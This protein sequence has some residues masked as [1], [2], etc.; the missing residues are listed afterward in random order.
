MVDFQGVDKDK[1]ELKVHGEKTGVG[2]GGGGNDL[3]VNFSNLPSSKQ[4]C[5]GKGRV[6]TGI[7]AAELTP[8]PASPCLRSGVHRDRSSR[9]YASPR[10]PL[11]QVSL[12]EEELSDLKREEG[13]RRAIL[14]ELGSQ[15]DRVA[16]S[17]ANKLAKVCEG[18]GLRGGHFGLQISQHSPLLII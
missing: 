17:I 13:E 14:L 15:R 1:G 18:E 8:H 4:L 10:L 5:G 3:A 7:E 6:F 12:M 2:R 11:S 16:L 9:A